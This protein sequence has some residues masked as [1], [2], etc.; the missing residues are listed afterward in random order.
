MRLFR[1]FWAIALLWDRKW[2]VLCQEATHPKDIWDVEVWGGLP[3]YNPD[4]TD[5]HE[6]VSWN[7]KPVYDPGTLIQPGVKG[8]GL[9]NPCTK[10]YFVDPV[11]DLFDWN[12]TKIYLNASGE[13]PADYYLNVIVKDSANNYSLFCSGDLSVSLPTPQDWKIN[14][15]LDGAQFNGHG[16]L[17]LRMEVPGAFVRSS[18][19]GLEQYWYC[20]PKDSESLYP[21]VYRA[22]VTTNTTAS[23][24]L[25]QAGNTS[26]SCTVSPATSLKSSYYAPKGPSTPMQPLIPHP[27]SSPPEQLAELAPTWDCTDMSLTYPHWVIEDG[28]TYI[29]SLPDAG[30]NTTVLNFTITSRATRVSHICSWAGGGSNLSPNS[31]R[32]SL[33]MTCSPLP[34]AP[35]DPTKTS[36]AATFYPANRELA[37]EQSWICGDTAGTYTR[38]YRTKQNYPMP[39]FC[40]E[41]NGRRCKANRQTIKG[42]LTE[43][44]LNYYPAAFTP[45]PGA[46]RPGCTAASILPRWIVSNFRFEE[47]RRMTS[48]NPAREIAISFRNTAFD[49]VQSCTVT[50]PESDTANSY[51]VTKWLHCHATPVTASHPHVK[52]YMRF[53]TTRATLSLN[54]TWYCADTDASRPLLFEGLVS[55]K[56]DFCGE[57]NSTRWCA[58]GKYDETTGVFSTITK[59]FAGEIIRTEV[60]PPNAITDPDPDP[61]EWSCTADSVG[62]PVV[63]RL[64]AAI[65]SRGV[66]EGAAFFSTGLASP[67]AYN[68]SR[69]PVSTFAITLSNSALTR[70][71]GSSLD[72][73]ATSSKLTPY[74]GSW[75]PSLKYSLMDS[76]PEEIGLRK[77]PFRNVIDWGF[78]FD[79]ERGYLEL[80]SSWFCED[81][82]PGKA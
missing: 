48:T 56:A 64:S 1:N 40:A 13:Y 32:V 18:A 76:A 29:P 72:I 31:S 73:G 35:P 78:R 42:Y 60:L 46:N 30:I 38:K 5:P 20:S 23:C 27:L 63:W 62:R 4:E 70:R 25:R 17:S 28:A 74:S 11:Y 43:P 79:A 75:E 9:P 54:Q 55:V 16:L 65:V 58:V 68:S 24:P 2:Y 34:G 51:P 6:T 52:T 81:K 50:L 53:D 69:P 10:S 26:Q 3:L 22:S 57:G 59:T 47:T 80:E 77:R 67:P 8:V 61:N 71:P 33:N 15:I 37:V 82:A 41:D 45:P 39:L 49:Y 12:V 21:H 36:F 7:A 14:C 44:L 19:L 66:P